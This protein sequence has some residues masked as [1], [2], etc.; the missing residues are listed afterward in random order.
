MTYHQPN[1]LKPDGH[2]QSTIGRIL[3]F[4]LKEGDTVWSLVEE[5]EIPV[6]TLPTICLVDDEPILRKDWD[7]LLATTSKVIFV[8]VPQGDLFKDVLRIV[9][10]LAL[11][12][13]APWAAGIIGPL[14]NI[15]SQLGLSL[16][17]AGIVI[18]G[19]FLINALLPPSLPKQDDAATPSPTYSL[20][21]QGNTARLFQP[22]PKQYGEH[23]IYPDF[24]A[25]PYSYFEDN[26]QIL[27]QL[28]VRGLGKYETTKVRVEDTEV[29]DSTTGFADG[30]AGVEIE[31][32]D[33][34]EP[35]TLFPTHVVTS[36]EV[37]GIDLFNWR[38]ANKDNDTQ[39][40]TITASNN[41]ISCGDTQTFSQAQPG[42]KIV[43]PSGTNAG[44][45][46]ILS[47]DTATK[48]IIVD[49]PLV[50]GSFDGYMYLAEE[51]QWSI[52]YIAN[53]AD[54]ITNKIQID[55]FFDRG[56]Y[57]ADDDGGISN[58]T[59]SVEAQARLIN[60]AGVALSD[61]VY[62]GQHTYTKATTTPQRITESYEVSDGRYEVR[63]RRSSVEDPRQRSGTSVSWG[64]LKAFIPDG[65]VY[66]DVSLIA[67]KMTVTGQLSQQ[68]SRR[69]NLIQTAILPVYDA[70]TE[71]WSDQPT[72]SIAWAA[73]DIA[74]NEDYGA[75]K[76]A[77]TIDLDQLVYL[78]G[79]WEDRD[80][81]FDGIF[82]SQQSC[83]DALVATLRVGRTLPILIGGQLSFRRRQNAVVP[84]GVFIP[85][86]IV[87]NSFQTDHIMF[88]EESPDDIIVEFI[89]RRTWKMNEV[90]CTIVGSTSEKPERQ[91]LFGITDRSHAWREG[92]F[93]A[94]FNAKNRIVAQFTT[95]LEGRLLVRADLIYVAHDLYEWG[96]TG[97]VITYV[98]SDRIVQL[99][100]PVTI[101]PDSYLMLRKRNGQGWGPVKINIGESDDE[102]VI[103]ATDLTT[104]E[105]SQGPI[106]DVWSYDS[107]LIATKFIICEQTIEYKRFTVVSGT[108]SDDTVDLVCILDDPSV[109]TVD[110]ASPP[111]ETYPY[112]DSTISDRPVI[113]SLLAVRHGGDP[114]GAP[115][116]DY[117]WSVASPTA[118]GG[119][120]L[121]ISYDNFNWIDL[122][123][124][125]LLAYSNTIFPGMLYAR[126]RG[127]A[128]NNGP[129][130]SYS[131]SFGTATLTPLPP[132]AVTIEPDFS[133]GTLL[134]SWTAGVRAKTYN[135]ELWVE[136]TLDS[137]TYDVKK[138]DIDV[139]GLSYFLSSDEVKNKGGPW[140]NFQI[141]VFSVN[142]A[143]SSTAT[144]Q[145]YTNFVPPNVTN[146]RLVEPYYGEEIRLDWESV[147]N[148]TSF[149]V[150]FYVASVL[151]KSINVLTSNY[152]LT[153]T[154]L[155]AAG[156]PWSTVTVGVIPVS[157]TLKGNEVTLVI[158][159]IDL[160]L[161]DSGDT[162]YWDSGDQMAWR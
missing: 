117:S 161:W 32:L 149:I 39:V 108:P 121:Q 112:G 158:T 118:T 115:V 133:A 145:V 120:Q 34:G 52:P 157:N 28:M 64:S 48:W 146:L 80:D 76:D 147:P 44:T 82:D 74:T 91:Q 105:G 57:W 51:D 45:Y 66:A 23:I 16:I 123:T 30:F 77:S 141:K 137:G 100:A 86:N 136:T 1:K 113:S 160:M 47:I 154:A 24:A 129:W 152:I 4:D 17:Q 78:D 139:S 124:G 97:E 40:F 84:K 46:T 143:G 68:A 75:G 43:I 116:I 50:D 156:G 60:S 11:A 98:P 59:A 56:I 126:V 49:G 102:I 2:Y 111:S 54:T 90:Q 38:A 3:S 53:P 96:L 19:S 26:K 155:L 151:V 92:I 63:T 29:W 21:A 71:T 37:A 162:I 110:E 72:R 15:T 70:D 25:Q 88:T 89:D 95:E 101:T 103:D 42:Q 132:S 94:A 10:T 81:H 159:E 69:F 58:A 5:N 128:D 140:N 130:E 73:Y 104:I 153:N 135:M 55:W 36:V 31:L 67:V 99:D 107:D 8:S 7:S 114:D 122:Y 18:A 62:I 14:L 61:W 22:I 148:V 87:R 142:T 127:L 150:N 41:K 144:T 79:V 119:Y 33:P 35:V 20:G 131:A 138:F 12:I 9:A 6:N 125:P 27:N 83:W 65:D 134:I 109:H 85:Q 93:A 13:V 106:A